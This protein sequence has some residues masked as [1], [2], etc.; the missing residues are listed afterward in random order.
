MAFTLIKKEKKK[1]K[2]YRAS[3]IETVTSL[4]EQ[5]AHDFSV[6]DVELSIFLK[7]QKAGCLGGRSD[8]AS[9]VSME[10]TSDMVGLSSALS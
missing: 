5:S 6:V 2:N 1:E 10:T 3:K 9:F 4:I 7:L 8:E